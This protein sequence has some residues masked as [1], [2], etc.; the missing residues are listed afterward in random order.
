M[1][2]TTPPRVQLVISG[3]F[4]ALFLISLGLL[5]GGYILYSQQQGLRLE[6]QRF[7]QRF[8]APAYFV[9]GGSIIVRSCGKCLYLGK[10]RPQV[11]WKVGKPKEIPATEQRWFLAVEE[12]PA[13]VEVSGVLMLPVHPAVGDNP[14][15]GFDRN[16]IQLA[17]YQGLQRKANIEQPP[18]PLPLQPPLS[19]NP[20]LPPPE[21]TVPADNLPAVQSPQ[22]IESKPEI[23]Q[24]P[25]ISEPTSPPAAEPSSSER[26]DPTSSTVIMKSP[27]NWRVTLAR[28]TIGFIPAFRSSRQ[29]DSSFAR[30]IVKMA[31]PD[32]QLRLVPER[33]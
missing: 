21:P 13:P 24:A 30:S 31:K 23:V 6:R 12:Q 7:E 5:G 19:N 14:A 10:L 16:Q 4:I 26:S 32:G 2:T 8:R 11:D 3:K 9:N 33:S 27:G 29:R 1:E 28:D 15:L 25:Q 17:L 22:A 20:V 18:Q